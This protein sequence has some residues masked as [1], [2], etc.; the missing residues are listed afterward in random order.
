MEKPRK[1][2]EM[3]SG[4]DKCCPTCKSILPCHWNDCHD[5]MST[6]IEGAVVTKEEIIR[7]IESRTGRS[8]D[9]V[10]GAGEE[11]HN[12]LTQRLGGKP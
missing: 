4:E 9:S 6:L 11:I 8:D 7:I 12:L 5:A 1:H 3:Y 2:N 10:D